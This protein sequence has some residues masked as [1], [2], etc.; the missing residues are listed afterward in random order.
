MR[1]PWS[2]RHAR[3]IEGT[4]RHDRKMRVY[5]STLK[6]Y[7]SPVYTLERDGKSYL[8]RLYRSQH[9]GS[10]AAFCRKY[11]NR[12]VRYYKNEISSGNSYRKIADYWW[13]LD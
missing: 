2:K 11:C 9:A 12:K 8:K 3:R 7:P 1:K 10:R 4:A 13:I 6:F 5:N